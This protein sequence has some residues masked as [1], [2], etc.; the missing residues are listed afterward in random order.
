MKH[1]IP[2]TFFTSFQKSC[3]TLYITFYQSWH[4]R[5]S[6]FCHTSNVDAYSDIYYTFLLNVIEQNDN[7]YNVATI[8]R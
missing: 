4:I 3:L 8:G 6:C 5:D 7:V 2:K 1:T